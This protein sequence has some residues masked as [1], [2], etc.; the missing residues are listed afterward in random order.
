MGERKRQA[1]GWRLL[2]EML[3][4]NTAQLAIVMPDGDNISISGAE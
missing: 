3:R 1:W 4:R 2:P